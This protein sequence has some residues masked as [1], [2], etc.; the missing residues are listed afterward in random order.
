[1]NRPGCGSDDSV[2]RPLP[3]VDVRIADDGEILVRNQGM[4]GYLGDTAIPGEIATGDLGRLDGDGNLYVTGRKKNLF[5]TAF[6]RNVSPEWPESELL[7]EPGICQACVFGEAMPL[8]TAVLVLDRTRLSPDAVAAS[9]AR[10]N[11]RLPDYARIGRY[12]VSDEAFSPANGMLTPNGKLCRENIADRYFR[13]QP[14]D[15]A[16]AN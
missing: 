13:D 16:T 12:L 7:H 9:I 14:A 2:G 15:I 10:V 4:A 3:G 11:L 8:N 6:G 1:L 5:I